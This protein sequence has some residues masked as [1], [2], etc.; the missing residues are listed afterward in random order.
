MDAQRTLSHHNSFIPSQVAI[1]LSVS[2]NPFIPLCYLTH[3]VLWLHFPITIFHFL[4]MQPSLLV[5]LKSCFLWKVKSYSIFFKV[6]NCIELPNS[7]FYV[8]VACSFCTAHISH[9]CTWSKG[10]P[11]KD[12]GWFVLNRSLE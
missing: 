10:H 12:S 7:K 8:E 1:A 9:V 11:L 4:V 2:V 6:S 5:T 3:L